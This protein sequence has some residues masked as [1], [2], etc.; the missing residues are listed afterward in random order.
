[1]PTQ[2]GIM[3]LVQSNQLIELNGSVTA[4]VADVLLPRIRQNGPLSEKA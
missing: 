1:M 2:I 3:P 4:G